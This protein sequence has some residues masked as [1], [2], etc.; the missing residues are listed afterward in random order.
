MTAA[1]LIKLRR[2]APA[3]DLT[4][5]ALALPPFNTIRP[6]RT[7]YQITHLHPKNLTDLGEA[8]GKHGE[9]AI[10]DT[11]WAA[12]LAFV[13]MATPSSLQNEVSLAIAAVDKC[14]TADRL[15]LRYPTVRESGSVDTPSRPSAQIDADTVRVADETLEDWKR[16]DRRCL[17]SAITRT[18]DHIVG[19]LRVSHTALGVVN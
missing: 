5:E 19:I 7:G 10:R 8:S 18:H 2:D 9:A 17:G 1:T 16:S 15:A 4:T 3:Q 13:R 11:E 6:R 14:R 12:C